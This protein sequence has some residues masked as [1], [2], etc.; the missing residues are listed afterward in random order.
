MVFPLPDQL[1]AGQLLVASPE[2]EDPHFARTVVLLLSHAPDGS[3][4]VVLNRPTD[5]SVGSVLSGWAGVGNDPDVLY[6]GGPVSR[7]SALALAELDGVP[8]RMGGAPMGWRPVAGSM[9]LID[10]DADPQT[11]S[12]SLRGMRVFAGYAGWSGGQLMGELG[13]GAWAVVDFRPEDAFTA[14]PSKLWSAVLRR[15]GG[16]LALLATRPADPRMN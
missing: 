12:G 7:N 13:E 11:L 6:A 1:S 4:G 2:L 14:H 3:L 9:G 16:D 10:L 5:R 15:Q 8:A